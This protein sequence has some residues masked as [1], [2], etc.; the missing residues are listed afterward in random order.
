MMVIRSS[1]RGPCSVVACHA[2]VQD[3]ARL[4]GALPHGVT[5]QVPGHWEKH[6]ISRREVCIQMM[7]SGKHAE[8][9]RG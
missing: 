2:R 7:G 1:E 6:A 5:T 3:P 8:A 4:H 9:L